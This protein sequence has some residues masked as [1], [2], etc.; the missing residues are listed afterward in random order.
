MKNSQFLVQ[1]KIKKNI[2]DL[3]NIFNSYQNKNSYVK[4]EKDKTSHLFKSKKKILR[5][6]NDLSLHNIARY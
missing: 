4:F 1:I 2:F 6:S 3:K 5:M